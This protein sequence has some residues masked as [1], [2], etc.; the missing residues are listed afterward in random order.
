MQF[1]WDKRKAQK[2][3]D[4]RGISFETATRLFASDHIIVSSDHESEKRWLAIG[5]IEGICFTIAFTKRG[6]NIRFITA[7]RARRN[8]ERNYYSHYPRRGA[9]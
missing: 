3:W 9:S 6:K 8:E 1:E 7:R 2:V 4:E 5:L